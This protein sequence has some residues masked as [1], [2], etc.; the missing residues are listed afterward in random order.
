MTAAA[1]LGVTRSDV[2]S[3]IRRL[4]KVLMKKNSTASDRAAAVPGLT[5]SDSEVACQLAAASVTGV[6]VSAVPGLTVSDS[7]VACQ[8]ASVSVSDGHDH[9]QLDDDASSVNG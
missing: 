7:E 9:K 3:F 4:D 1:A 2:D 8:L 6:S 5:V